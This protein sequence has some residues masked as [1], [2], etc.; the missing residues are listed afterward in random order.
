MKLAIYSDLHL[1]FNKDLKLRV[2]EGVDI[3]ILAG[4]IV[5]GKDVR[6]IVD[7]C[8]QYPDKKIIFVAGNH[9]FYNSDVIEIQK[10]YQELSDSIENLHFLDNSFLEIDGV[11]FHGTTLWTGF[12][13]KGEAWKSVGKF[14]SQRNV[15]DFYTIKVRGSY[16]SADIMEGL[17]KQSCQW[18]Q[19]S[20]SANKG[21]TNVVITHWPPLIDCKHPEIESNILDTYFNNDLGELVGN[22]DIDLW[23]YGHNHWSDE[24]NLYD[25]RFIS[26]Q[27]GYP[28]EKT[29]FDDCVITI[30]D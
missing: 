24:F 4:D 20:L 13:A 27:L 14:E 5:V 17:H 1:E 9:E 15:S 12:L 11:M 23:V 3:I 30:S 22:L 25:T 28:R 18:L 8:E 21:K 29:G 16:M 2:A 10:F 19:R 26:N 6:F 7:L